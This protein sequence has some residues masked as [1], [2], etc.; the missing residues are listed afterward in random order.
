MTAYD[1]YLNKRVR[2]VSTNGTSYTRKRSLPGKTGTVTRICSKRIGVL[3]DGKRNDASLYGVFWFFAGNLEILETEKE[4]EEM[5][6]EGFKNVAIVN[7]LED[8]GKKDYAFALFDED[9]DLL[10]KGTFGEDE[11][12]R[13]L[14]V[15]N[16]KGKDNRILGKVKTIM[17]VE[18]YGKGVTA[19]VVGVVNMKAYNARVD[20]E[21]RLKEL[22]KK[23]KEIELA[24][25]QEIN[26]RKS[27][28]Y[29]EEMASKYSDN[30]RLS[31]LVSEL[32]KLGM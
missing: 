3:V 17:S 7:L 24:L 4:S 9:M 30:P 8:Y 20:E 12:F 28:E 15:V 25:E 1:D 2:V 22:A 11:Y 21:K 29:Y 19:Q 32:K 5:K 31:E 26:K 23:K 18:D 16:A 6:M 13:N 14:V 10:I 27:I